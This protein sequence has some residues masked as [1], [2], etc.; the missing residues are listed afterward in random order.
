[1]GSWRWLTGFALKCGGGFPAIGIAS[2]SDKPASARSSRDRSTWK[3]ACIKRD[4]A[5]RLEFSE[6]YP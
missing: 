6:R 2:V 1:M 4:V 3:L 5:R